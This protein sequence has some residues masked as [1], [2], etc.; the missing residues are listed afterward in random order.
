MK[1]NIWWVF[2]PPYHTIQIYISDPSLEGL[3]LSLKS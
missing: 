2:L 3:S 1:L